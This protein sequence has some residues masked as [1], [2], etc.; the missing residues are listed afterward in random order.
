MPYE[1]HQ[2]YGSTHINTIS[3]GLVRG[4][5]IVSVTGVR[6]KS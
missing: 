1:E 4:V 3:F 6:Q 5:D 2:M